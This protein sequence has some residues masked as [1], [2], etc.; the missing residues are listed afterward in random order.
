MDAITTLLWRLLG[1]ILLVAGLTISITIFDSL[2]RYQGET[3]GSLFK[4]DDVLSQEYTSVSDVD[5]V[6]AKF[7]RGLILNG[8]SSRNVIQYVGDQYEIR[9]TSLYGEGT[10]VEVVECVVGLDEKLLFS[11][12]CSTEDVF[13]A[14]NYDQWVQAGKYTVVTDSRGDM[15]YTYRE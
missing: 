15:V 5:F 1:P 3:K 9:L 8:V 11:E 10:R 4:N 6:E 13:K 7:I 14:F 12:Y 2:S